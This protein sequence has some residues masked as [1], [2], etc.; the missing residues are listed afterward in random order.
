[1]NKNYLHLLCKVV[2]LVYPVKT[3][4]CNNNLTMH[5]KRRTLWK[6]KM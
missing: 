1:M 3:G 4:K 2:K 6:E 5:Q